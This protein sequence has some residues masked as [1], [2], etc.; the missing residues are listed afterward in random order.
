MDTAR[1]ELSAAGFDRPGTVLRYGHWGRPVLVFP[2]EAGRAWDFADRGML[3][4]VTP[5]VDAGRV[6]LY[7]VDSA[8]DRTW[9]DRSIPL[10][11]RARGHA[12]YTSWVT[13]RARSG[14]SAA[15]SQVVS[16][17][18]RSDQV[19]RSP[20]AKASPQH[21]SCQPSIHTT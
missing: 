13:D 3:A 19:T 15:S 21:C 5:L 20:T 18:S 11:D 1:V 6:K 9:S 8:D 7:C 14:P 12:A 4:A 17:A 10:E 2:C 16:D